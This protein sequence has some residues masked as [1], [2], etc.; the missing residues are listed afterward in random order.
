MIELSEFR[1][2]MV[3]LSEEVKETGDIWLAIGVLAD[4]LG[5]EVG[6]KLE[7]WL[8]KEKAKA[9]R[10]FRMHLAEGMR[11]KNFNEVCEFLRKEIYE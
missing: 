8:I 3:R 9:V 11:D 2:E 4:K 7:E 10:S 5:S 6:D 1:V